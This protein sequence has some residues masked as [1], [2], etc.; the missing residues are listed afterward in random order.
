MGIFV[1]DQVLEQQGGIQPL[2]VIHET[3]VL[4]ELKWLHQEY[5]NLFETDTVKTYRRSKF[6]RFSIGQDFDAET[7][8]HKGIRFFKDEIK[9]HCGYLELS[10]YPTDDDT[11]LRRVSIVLNAF[12]ACCKYVYD[13]Y[14]LANAAKLDEAWAVYRE[15]KKGA[16]PCLK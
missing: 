9:R 12:D 11:F 10:G 7:S 1:D 2:N 8:C 5:V 13:A 15:T 14:S 16:S 6:P 4:D 3:A